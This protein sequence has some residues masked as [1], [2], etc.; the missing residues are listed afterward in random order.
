VRG[1]AGGVKRVGAGL[2]PTRAA[3]KR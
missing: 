1:E 2:C 3:V